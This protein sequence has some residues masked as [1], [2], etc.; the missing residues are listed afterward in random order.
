[1]IGCGD[2]LSKREIFT[3]GLTYPQKMT[4]ESAPIELLRRS[5]VFSRITRKYL[6]FKGFQLHAA[7]LAEAWLLTLEGL[8]WG[9]MA[10]FPTKLSTDSVSKL[11]SL[12]KSCT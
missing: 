9:G 4:R 5:S 7:G 2:C 6:I 11:K 1:L 12:F 10:T 3:L 8:S